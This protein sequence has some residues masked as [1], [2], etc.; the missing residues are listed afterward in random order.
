MAR[1][2][3]PC[4]FQAVAAIERHNCMFM[5]TVPG[6]NPERPFDH[7]PPRTTVVYFMMMLHLTEVL[8]AVC[9]RQ[10][11]PDRIC[12]AVWIDSAWCEVMG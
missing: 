2:D 8:S 7:I 5:S 10:P 1:S 9:F 12:D 6:Y 3:V 11:H 4:L